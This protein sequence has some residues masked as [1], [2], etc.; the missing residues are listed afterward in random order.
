[1]N[2]AQ[3]GEAAKLL[4]LNIDSVDD[5]GSPVCNFFN[6]FKTERDTYDLKLLGIASVLLGAG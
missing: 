6:H 5:E 1:M 4:Y 3:L 2:R